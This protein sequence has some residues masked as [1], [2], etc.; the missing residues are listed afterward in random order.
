MVRRITKKEIEPSRAQAHTSA[1]PASKYKARFSLISERELEGENLN[2]DLGSALEQGQL[3]DILGAL[4]RG[5]PGNVDGCDAAGSGKRTVGECD[6]VREKLTQQTGDMSL[7][8]AM[9]RSRRRTHKDAAMLIGPNSGTYC[10]THRRIVV[11]DRVM[12]RSAI[13]WTRS[14]AFFRGPQHLGSTL[15]VPKR[16]GSG[17][18]KSGGFSVSS[19]FILEPVG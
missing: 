6:P 18:G 7:A 1:A 8:P 5:E 4:I 9:N 11:W 17:R 3:A 16:I 13:I 15:S 10:C 14:S 19:Y 2:T 12:P